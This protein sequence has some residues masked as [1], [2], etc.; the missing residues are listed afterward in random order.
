MSR[1]RTVADRLREEYNDLLVEIWRVASH[2]EAEIRYLVLP[3]FN[4]LERHERLVVKTRVKDCESAIKKLL[5][6][7]EGNLPEV[8]DEEKLSLLQLRDL[9][10]VRVLVFPSER[11]Q[12]VDRC[13]RDESASLRF[14]WSSLLHQWDP[15]T[16]AY[17]GEEQ[18][19]PKYHGFCAG[20][21][22][23]IMAEYQIVPMLIGQFWDVEHSA[24]YKP[25][26]AAKGADKD[27]KLKQ[28]RANVERALYSFERE[29]ERYTRSS[30][31]P[32][33][34]Y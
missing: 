3:V 6:R 33:S 9:V 4:R 17:A 7:F 27:D 5:G 31:M 12:E 30:S 25:V 13:L 11:L 15:D 24:L 14:A 34:K 26:G 29:F 19:A 18:F 23:K 1:E 8:E 21:S 10:G 2:L 16:I 28:L 32:P 22:K 20:A